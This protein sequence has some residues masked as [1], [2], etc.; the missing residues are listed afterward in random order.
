MVELAVDQNVE[1]AERVALAMTAAER[2]TAEWEEPAPLVRAVVW[3]ASQAEFGT[4]WEEVWALA[5]TDWA[6]ALA[7]SPEVWAAPAERFRI[8]VEQEFVRR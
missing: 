5:A 4:A 1:R 6:D 8:L 3:A 2:A 7:V